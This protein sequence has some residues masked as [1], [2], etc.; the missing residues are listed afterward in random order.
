MLA[1]LSPFFLALLKLCGAVVLSNGSVWRGAYLPYVCT[2]VLRGFVAFSMLSQLGAMKQRVVRGQ[3][4]VIVVTYVPQHLNRLPSHSVLFGTSCRSSRIS[5]PNYVRS[6][7]CPLA[8]TI[9]PLF[10]R[11]LYSCS[12]ALQTRSWMTCSRVLAG[13]WTPWWSA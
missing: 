8:P 10:F 13:R 2:H 7:L 6:A 3:D 9:T 11:A 12:Q 1:P 4:L 5:P